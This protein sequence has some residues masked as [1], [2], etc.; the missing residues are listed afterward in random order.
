[1]SLEKTAE[2]VGHNDEEIWGERI[3]LPQTTL[4][5]DPLPRV[6]V[7]E[8]CSFAGSKEVLDPIT[9]SFREA[10]ELKNGAETVPGNAIEGFV[11][12]KFEDN[13]GAF[14]LVAAVEEVRSIDKII[15]QASAQNKAR[16]ISA[17]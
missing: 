11:E 17:N 3:P 6:S 9:P 8:H 2:D 7:Q 4:A 14:P 12:V 10:T 13:G 15:G 1:M 5:V 16:L